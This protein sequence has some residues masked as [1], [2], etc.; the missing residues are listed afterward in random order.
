[1][2]NDEFEK[3]LPKNVIVRKYEQKRKIF[4]EYDSEIAKKFIYVY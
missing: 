2:Q 4:A 3:S 1:M